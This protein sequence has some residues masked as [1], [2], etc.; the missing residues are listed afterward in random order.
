MSESEIFT[1]QDFSTLDLSTDAGSTETPVAGIQDVTIIPNVSIETLYTADSIKV[2]DKMQHEAAVNVEIGYAF[3]DGA[4]VEQWLGGSGSTGTSLTDTSDPQE[5]SITGTF[6]S[7]DDS[8][9]INVTVEGITFEEM[10]IFDASR[11]EY[12]QWDLS[13]TGTDITNFDV[14]APA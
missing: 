10:P 8:M 5:Y 11:G 13:G 14:S 9:Q 4:V 2:A 6:D 1:L 3:F 12:A 7:R